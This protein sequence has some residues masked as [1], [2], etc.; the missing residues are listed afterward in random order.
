MISWI[1]NTFQKHFK[2]IFT[3][4][5]AVT[6]ISFIFTIGST[7]GIGRTEKRITN[8]E[9]FG[10][11]LASEADTTR[12]L[13]D[14]RLS[15]SLQ[16]SQ[17]VYDNNTLQR[18]AFDRAA[19]LSLADQLHLPAA[20]PEQIKAFIQTLPAFQG[21]DGQ[22]DAA[23]YSGF[24]QDVAN[25]GRLNE[26]DI[27]RVI[28][29]DVRASAAEQ[30]LAGPG[31]VLPKDVVTQL[32]LGDT[33]WT[34]S[35][36][37]VD[38]ASYKPA[39]N[40]S[41][42]ELA[43]FFGENSFRYQIQPKIAVSAIDFPYRLFASQVTAT[44]AD[45]RAYFETHAAQFPAPEVKAPA[46][47]NA[48]VAYAAVKPK[49][50][51]TLREEKARE[52]AMK[53]ASDFEDALYKNSIVRGPALGQ[54]IAAHKLE[55]KQ[56]PPFTADEPP[57]EINSSKEV[58]DAAFRLDSNRY[59]SDPVATPSGA[60]I[61][62]WN[63]TIPA[64][65]PQLA[66]VKAKVV[67]DYTENERRKRFVELGRQM[68]SQIEASLK[69]GSSFDKAA[70]AVAA[71]DSVK[72]DVKAWPA[73]ALRDRPKDLPITAL[74]SLETLKKGQVSDMA[75]SEDKGILVYATEQKIPVLSESNPHY[76][77]ARMILARNGARSSPGAELS[78]LVESELKRTE[79][80][81]K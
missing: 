8:R 29:D 44:D 53:A 78:E 23:R 71:A 12:L 65:Q 56:L 77:E 13:S 52:L 31:Y 14:A 68:K 54:F 61:L 33:S 15:A 58:A 73:F 67:A 39:V 2:V 59:Y 75:V 55:V 72:V 34:L 10:H 25:G 36:A 27:V 74:T 24:R 6:I 70:T 69:S 50:E 40:P 60:A 7:P 28:G 57:V 32:Q 20:T 47:P 26:S 64:R 63:S 37:T 76:A 43:K 18:Y 35:T 48:D 21:Q 45:I 22:F 81:I 16:M 38:F 5:L 19:A 4:L 46:K 30:M 51:A 49:V 11:N 9:F 80:P 66:E 1:Q 79:P 42:A 3:V 17:E 41:D 62:I